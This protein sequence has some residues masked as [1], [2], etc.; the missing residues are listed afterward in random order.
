VD[1]ATRDPALSLHAML[2][3][4]PLGAITSVLAT[5]LVIIFFVTSSDSGSLVDDMVTSG[6]HPHPPK[7][8]RVFWAVSEGA[9]AAT[10]LLAGGLQA[11]RTASLTSGLPMSIILLLAAWG[12]YRSLRIDYHTKGLP[13]QKELRP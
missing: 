9:V 1:V 8:Q 13:M 10:L 4:L 11:L 5:V 6:G 12:L 2:N 7:A 3:A